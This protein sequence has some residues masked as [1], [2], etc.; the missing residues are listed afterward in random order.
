MILANLAMLQ[1]DSLGAIGPAALAV[2]VGALVL[3]SLF[4]V[5]VSRYKRC[6]ANK[7]LVI[8]GRVGGGQSARVISGGGTFV[9]PV[10]QEHNFLSLLPLQIDINL[11]DALSLE[12]IR[13]KVPSQVTVAI[14]DT[15]E[16]QQNAAA[17]LMGSTPIE[18]SRLAENIIFGQMRQVI[19]S[20]RIEDIN[21]DRDQFRANIEHALEPE[22]KK[23]GLKL[24]NVNIKDLNDESGYIEAI[25]REAGARAVQKARGDVAE[26]EKLGEIAVAMA[27]QEREIAVA[28]ATREREIGVKSAARDTAVRV[29]ELDRETS[30]AQQRAAFSR[31][32]E[33]ADADR[34]R[35]IAVAA[36]NAEA[37]QGEAQAEQ[38]RRIAVAAADAHAISGEAQA[39]AQIAAAQAELQ[40]RQ[41]EAF[42]QG[43]TRRRIAEAKVAEAENRAQALAALAEA[44]R[45]EAER[46]AELEAPAKA[47]KAKRIVEAEAQGQSRRIE[48]EAEAAAVLAR[49]QAEAQGEYE[50]LAK[51]AEGLGRIVEKCGGADE[52]YKLLMIEH[53]DHLATAAAQAVANIKFDKVVVW[54][55]GNGAN[56]Q[57][58]DVGVGSFVRDL[59]GTIPPVLQALRDIGGVKLPDSLLTMVPDAEPAP[60]APATIVEDGPSLSAAQRD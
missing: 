18:V 49:L 15:Q 29:A 30:V 27:T 45:I 24:I 11:H 22:L 48:A 46:R 42:E 2:V 6:P 32:T 19:A 14:G 23:I 36:A 55:G 57:G 10:I 60:Q 39:K 34:Q 4:M 5:F 8:S 9:W 54:G 35:R 58:G 3:T 31:D 21:R 13:V 33:I 7:V 40:V 12:N 25:G 26:Q 52:A 1:L 28:N 53:M 50:K 43:E 44:E 59:A 38:A 51:K 41:A 17:R 16:Y 37:V 20:M 47:E 56:G